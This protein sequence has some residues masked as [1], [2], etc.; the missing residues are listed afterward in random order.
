MRNILD[1]ILY[2]IVCI[3][4]ILVGIILVVAL[5]GAF[6]ISFLIGIVGLIVVGI[7]FVIYLLIEF[8]C[9]KFKVEKKTNK[10]GSKTIN[11]QKGDTFDYRKTTFDDNEVIEAKYEEKDED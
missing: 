7:L 6:G 4:A 8:V 11:I 5:V 10:D 2:Y 3:S 9:G 1:T